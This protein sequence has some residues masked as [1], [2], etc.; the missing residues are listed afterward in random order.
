MKASDINSEYINH[1]NKI[2][3]LNHIA[4]SIAYFGVEQG[5]EKLMD[6]MDMTC[7]GIPE[8][9]YC[10]VIDLSAQE[11]FL[12]LYTNIAEYRFAY[13]VTN[14][15]KM[16]E[17]FIIPVKDF[18]R[19]TGSELNVGEIPSLQEAYKVL[20][21]IILDDLPSEN[22]KEIISENQKEILWKGTNKRHEDAWSKAGGKIENYLEL[23][24]D[25][26]D[27]LFSRSKIQLNIENDQTFMLHFNN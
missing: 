7:G 14:V 15:L 11:V 23:L 6:N 5:F 10:Q 27:G 9:D 8:G 13:A 4:E 21:S 1:F 20:Y 19:R 16:N 12:S 26:A 2:K 24:K 17:K 3:L 22:S 25:F 18:L